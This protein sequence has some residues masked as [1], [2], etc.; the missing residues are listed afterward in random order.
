MKLPG[1]ESGS[2]TRHAEA[3]SL[4][5]GKDHDRDRPGRH[6]SARPGGIDRSERRHDSQ[7]AVERTA[8]RNRVKVR[9]DDEGLLTSGRALR[10]PPRPQVAVAVRLDIEASL[11]S[12]GR[13]PLTALEFLGSIGEPSISTGCRKAA[14]GLQLTPQR[15][16]Y[17]HD[18]KASPRDQ[19]VHG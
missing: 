14:D 6:K 11:R 13:K 7:W 15:V 5:I 16:E 18:R 8:I 10:H 3:G 4:L 1:H 17:R 19:S 9:A 2:G 12:S